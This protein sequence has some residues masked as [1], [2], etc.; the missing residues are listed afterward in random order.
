MLAS[1]SGDAARTAD[2]RARKAE[3]DRATDRYNRLIGTSGPITE[4]A[5]LAGL[6]ETLGRWFDA[7]AWC[8]LALQRDPSD[9]DLRAA[10]PAGSNRASSPSRPPPD[11][12]SRKP[13]ERRRV[14][15][16]SPPRRSRRLVP[17]VASVRGRR[18][19]PPGSGSSST[20]AARRAGSFP[21]PHPAASPCSTTTAT[22]FSMS[23]RSKAAPSPRPRIG[24]RGRSPVP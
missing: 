8:T 6:A 17:S 22:A 21:K 23:T 2:L 15:G 7:W 10:R 14:R 24:H 20:T 19:G 18:R 5:E 1:G 4:Y 13:W 3:I 11:R 12:P 9:P 16:R